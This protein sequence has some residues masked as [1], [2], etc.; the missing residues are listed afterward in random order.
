LQDLD[1][2]VSLQPS[3]G[4]LWNE[5]C[6]IRGT[7]GEVQGALSDCNEAIRLDPK[8]ATRFNSRGFAYLKTEQWDLAI[9]DFNMALQIDSKLPGALYGRGYAKQK[10]GD[11]AGAKSD[12]AAAR[13][14][15]KDVEAEFAVYGIH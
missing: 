13:A 14:I 15:K 7:V 6:W 9:A 4:A 3:S 10:K 8:V 2:A 1:R 11:A 5:R 12:I